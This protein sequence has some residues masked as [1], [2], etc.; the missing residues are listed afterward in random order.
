MEVMTPVKFV[1]YAIP[2]GRDIKE[3]EVYRDVLEADILINVPI[4]KHHSLARLSLGGKNLLGVVSAANRMHRNLGQ[5]IADLATLVRPSLT[6]V[7][8]VR[9]LTKHGPTGGSLDDV[10]QTDTIIASHDLWRHRRKI[11]SRPAPTSPG[12]GLGGFSTAG[13][14]R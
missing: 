13:G 7:D 11:S 6:L 4:A 12:S 1:K 10:Q 2:D 3:W 14:S 9:I 8:A 5:R